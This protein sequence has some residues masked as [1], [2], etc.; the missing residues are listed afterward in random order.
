[1]QVERGAQLSKKNK[2]Q[3][4][5]LDLMFE[6]IQSPGDFINSLWSKRVSLRKD[7]TK[8]FLVGFKMVK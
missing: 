2:D 6:C 8:N 7:K 4:T 1:M 5:P 3:K